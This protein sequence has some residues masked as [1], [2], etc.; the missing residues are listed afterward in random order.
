MDEVDRFVEEHPRYKGTAD[1]VHE[2]VRIRME[3]IRKIPQLP[4]LPRFQHFNI[5][6]FG[7]RITDT[8]SPLMADIY[9]KPE[10]IWCDLDKSSSCEHINYALTVPKIQKIVRQHIKEG[11]KLP[12]I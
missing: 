6:E 1:F 9:F 2:A 8:Q 4:P 12:D 11:W 3:E 5:S 10:G 7:V